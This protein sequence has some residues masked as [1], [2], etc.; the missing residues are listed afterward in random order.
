MGI[1]SCY[2]DSILNTLNVLSSQMQVVL[3][4]ESI[5]KDVPVS[6]TIAAVG[7][8]KCVV[9][10]IPDDKIDNSVRIETDFRKVLV[11]VGINIYVPYSEGTKGGVNAFD[12]IFNTFLRANNACLNEAKL[13]GTKYS[14]EAQCLVTET[15]FVFESDVSGWIEG[16]PPIVMG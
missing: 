6:K 4:H 3:A 16:P 10:D 1:C 8:K 7:I 2:C 9:S 12:S 14:R 11:T 13:L 15:E 5:V